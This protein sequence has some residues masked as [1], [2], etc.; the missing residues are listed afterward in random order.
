MSGENISYRHVQH[1]QF[2]RKKIQIEIFLKYDDGEICSFAELFLQLK[3]FYE[4]VR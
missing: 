4:P 1:S 3:Y 2:W